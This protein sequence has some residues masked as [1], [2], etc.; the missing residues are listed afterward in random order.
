MQPIIDIIY[1]L[2]KN[3]IDAYLATHPAAC[4]YVDRGDSITFDF[5]TDK[6]TRDNAW[7]DLDLSSI[8]PENTQAVNL[9]LL[10]KSTAANKTFMLRRR[11]YTGWGS[12]FQAHTQVANISYS[13]A[14]VLAVD[15]DR[16][17]QY[18]VKDTTVSII[19][20]TIRG[21]FVGSFDEV[22][23]VNREL[24]TP[25][26]FTESDLTF[27]NA[28]HELDLSAIVPAGATAINAHLK[29]NHSTVPRVIFFR[30][31]GY[32]KGFGTCALRLVVANLDHCQRRA[33]GISSDRKIEYKCDAPAY[34]SI[35]IKIKGWWY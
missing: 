28:W 3:Y 8:V 6:F 34:D 20:L 4:Y 15:S 9:F 18:K 2:A 33:I 35:G 26:D 21:W 27:D 5:A 24:P 11:G 22:G 17:I 16:K 25:S 1:E 29:A 30:Q 31:A 23:Y 14:C 12:V 10:I 13:T 32:T 19:E 7:H